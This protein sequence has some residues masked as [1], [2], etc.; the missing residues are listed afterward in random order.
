METIALYAR[1]SV[2][3]EDLKGQIDNL[4]KYPDYSKYKVIKFYESISGIINPKERK[5]FIKME[6]QIIKKEINIVVVNSLDRLSRNVEDMIE[7]IKN[8][9]KYG[10]K[11]VSLREHLEADTKTA[12][13]KFMVT[14]LGAF[15]EL[16]RKWIIE[17]LQQG[18]KIAMLTGKTK[19]GKPC[20]REKLK[21]NVEEIRRRRNDGESLKKIADSMGVSASTI[22]GRIK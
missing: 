7:T 17:K 11:L 13:G 5:E 19:T 14:L 20:H 12:M 4:E 10:V 9:E 21:L 3:E 22:Y 2:S 6:E 18:R 15:A 1:A 16:D 8:F